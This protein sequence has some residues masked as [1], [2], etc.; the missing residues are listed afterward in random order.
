MTAPAPVFNEPGNGKPAG[1]PCPYCG[2]RDM[3]GLLAGSCDSAD[4]RTAYLDDDRA[5]ERL[6][7]Q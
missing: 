3:P 2:V 6:L 1:I 5:M 7:D 4:C